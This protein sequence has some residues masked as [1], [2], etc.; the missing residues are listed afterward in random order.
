MK[1]KTLKL[2]FFPKAYF[3]NMDNKWLAVEK[4][5]DVVCIYATGE[6]Y[7]P[8]YAAIPLCSP[9]YFKN[10][11]FNI[12]TVDHDFGM[13]LISAADIRIVLDYERKTCAFNKNTTRYAS[14]NWGGNCHIPWAEEFDKLFA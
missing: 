12:S 7:S 6:N 1:I 5:K 2:G 10:T 4:E 11:V 3:F 13:V 14:D 9:Q 8:I